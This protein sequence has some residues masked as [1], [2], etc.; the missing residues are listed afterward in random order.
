MPRRCSSR[1]WGAHETR[2]AVPSRF[3]HPTLFFRPRPGQHQRAYETLL[4]LCGDEREACA[5][6]EDI[7]AVINADRE[8]E[9]EKGWELICRP[10]PGVR[11]MLIVV[12]GIAFAQQ[13]GRSAAGTCGLG[14]GAPAMAR[15][16]HQ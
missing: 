8:R 1:C 14:V 12:I 10:T 5:T 6:Q 2:P 3:F 13:V 16:W 15:P 9:G 11:R 7:A 4:K